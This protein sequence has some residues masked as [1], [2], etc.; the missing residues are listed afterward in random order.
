MIRIDDDDD[1]VVLGW[2]HRSTYDDIHVIL[3]RLR[4][5]IMMESYDDGFN[6]ARCDVHGIIDIDNDAMKAKTERNIYI[7]TGWAAS[8]HLQD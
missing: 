6:D 5:M 3:T 4:M 1:S 7:P 2:K 8:L